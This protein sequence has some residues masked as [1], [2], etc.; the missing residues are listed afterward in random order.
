MYK[1]SKEDVI[2][3]SDLAKLHVSNVD[4]YRKDLEDILNMIDDIE[5]IEIK[6]DIMISPS[7]NENIFSNKEYNSQVD[8]LLN[9]KN[10]A[11]DFIKVEVE[12]D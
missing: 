11:G 3:V 1:L 7:N 4:K 5:S 2:H 9:A 8:V 6:S 10:K 12:N